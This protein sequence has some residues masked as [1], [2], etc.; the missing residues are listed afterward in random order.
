MTASETYCSCP[1]NSVPSG[2][3]FSRPVH[4]RCQSCEEH[5]SIYK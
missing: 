3:S 2:V 1:S 4:I 5:K